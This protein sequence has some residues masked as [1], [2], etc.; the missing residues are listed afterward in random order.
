MTIKLI[1]EA[2]IPEYCFQDFVRT[3]MEFND[4]HPDADFQI[5]A[6]A[7]G[8]NTQKVVGMLE[9]LDLVTEVMKKQ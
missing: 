4:G 9:E 6:D 8:L 3:M 7:A 1:I 5:S 2:N